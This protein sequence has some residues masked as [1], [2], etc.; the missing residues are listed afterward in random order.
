V[1]NGEKHTQ[2]M[3][4]AM[5]PSW[6]EVKDLMTREFCLHNMVKKLEVEFWELKQDNGEHLA[7]TTRFHELRLLVPYLVTPLFRAIEKYIDGL[8]MQIQ[9]TILGRDPATLEDA[10]YLAVTLSD[11]HVKAGTLTRKYS[12][13]PS[14]K[15]ADKA[16]AESAKEVKA[17]SSSGNGNKKRKA[18][19]S[20]A[21]TTSAA[22]AVTINQVASPAQPLKK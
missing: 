21:V 19:R 16:V 10:I 14:E 12:K 11:N 15:P 1:V 2:G 17:E 6:N 22:S 5:A 4:A 18:T 7:Y 20:F 8:P 3:D 9:D 13:K